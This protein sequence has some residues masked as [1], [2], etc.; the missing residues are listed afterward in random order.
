[1]SLKY[2]T[3]KQFED[4]CGRVRGWFHLRVPPKGHIPAL[5]VCLKNC[6]KNED[7]YIYGN[8]NNV[9]EFRLQIY[10]VYSWNLSTI[11]HQTELYNCG[12]VIE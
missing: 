3:S 9:L 10:F 7:K 8:T 4:E 5:P 11:N 2:I 6:L 12:L 1:M